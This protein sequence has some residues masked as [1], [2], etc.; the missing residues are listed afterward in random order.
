MTEVLSVPMHMDAYYRPSTSPRRRT[1]QPASYSNSSSSTP[2]SIPRS[3]LHQHKPLDTPQAYGSI[4]ASSIRHSSSVIS[5][6]PVPPQPDRGQFFLGDAY[7]DMADEELDFPTYDYAETITPTASP[8]MDEAPSPYTASSLTT[9]LASST[10][11]SSI[12]SG[13]PSR[14]DSPEPV[15]YTSLDDNTIKPEPSRHVD[16]LSHEWKEE[17]IWSSWRYMVSKRDVYQNSA[18][19]ENASWR[20]WAKCKYKLKT[21]S[22][23]KLNW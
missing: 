14:Q 22:P 18:R 15:V 16:Y 21:V 19:L 9:S 8:N 10:T 7:D 20:T 4:H 5:R 11:S 23:E 3:H 17:E 1:S 2:L 6:V 13:V 12:V